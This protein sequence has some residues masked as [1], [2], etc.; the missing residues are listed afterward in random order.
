[1]EARQL[2]F[3][4]FQS[5]LSRDQ[6]PYDPVKQSSAWCR[7]VAGWTMASVRADHMAALAPFSHTSELLAL[8]LKLAQANLIAKRA[9]QEALDLKFNRRKAEGRHQGVVFGGVFFGLICGM[10]LGA[11]A[12]YLSTIL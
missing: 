4:S 12:H 5:G 11:F 6:N 8:R 7:W 3:A 10:I 1:M 2:G 9:H